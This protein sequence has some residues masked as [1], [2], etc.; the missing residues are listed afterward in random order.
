MQAQ[1]GQFLDGSAKLLKILRSWNLHQTDG[2]LCAV[3]DGL[4]AFVAIE[5]WRAV[6]E[7][8]P[9]SLMNP[10]SRHSLTTMLR[11]GARYRNAARALYRAAKKHP[12]ARR[13]E[14]VAVHLPSSAFQRPPPPSSPTS[15]DGTTSRIFAGQKKQHDIVGRM[16]RALKTDPAAARAAFAAQA[17]NTLADGK[18]HA[19]V[20]L[21]SAILESGPCATPRVVCASKDACYLCHCLL[22]AHAQLHTPR[23]HGRLYPGWRLPAT[24]AF[25]PLQAALS[26]TLEQKI[27]DGAG[28]LLSADGGR[29]RARRVHPYPCE[30]T[31]STAVLSDTT[32]AV[33]EPLPVDA[34]VPPSE[35]RSDATIA[36]KSPTPLE[37]SPLSSTMRDGNDQAV[38]SRASSLRSRS[39]SIGESY[40]LAQGQVVAASLPAATSVMYTA[41][42][43]RVQLE[44][45]A[46]RH[47]G[48][49]VDA[50]RRLEYRIQQLTS[51]EAEIL[52]EG[53]YTSIV[54]ATSLA[55]TE[56][57]TYKL[58]ELADLY[59][60]AGDCIFRLT[61]QPARQP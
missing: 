58:H 53:S 19:E 8:I 26:K 50:S 42:A 36:E 51:R 15:L 45:T 54:D 7:L 11:K 55:T 13:M 3:I 40:A 33:A 60:G 9:D 14:A 17:R 47:P 48:S 10:T 41:D 22:R 57:R 56:D 52:R 24:P 59:L 28:A 18:F 30:S 6:V 25:R 5:G 46:R 16:C 49:G 32:I 21:L 39:W 38:G 43:L 29:R 20:Q 35:N 1:I 4:W 44:Y 12:V 27:R 2:E 37:P 23:C 61:L 34:G 31:C